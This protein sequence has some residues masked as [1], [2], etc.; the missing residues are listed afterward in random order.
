MTF[1]LVLELR[2]LSFS[3]RSS[4]AA[5]KASAHEGSNPSFSDDPHDDDQ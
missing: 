1:M 3:K 2:Y 5:K 4:A